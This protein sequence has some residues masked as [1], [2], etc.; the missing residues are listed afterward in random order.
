MVDAAQVQLTLDLPFEEAMGVEDFI[1]ASPNAQAFDFIT[2]WPDW[3]ANVAVLCG[4]SGSGKTHL[5]NIWTTLSGARQHKAKNLRL[6]VI[7]QWLETGALVV[8]DFQAGWFDEA[9]LFHL[10]NAVRGGPSHLLITADEPP[11]KWGLQTADIMSR[12]RAAVP[13]E[14]EI[15]DDALMRHIFVKQFSDRQI[16]VEPNVIDYLLFRI[17]RSLNAVRECV[18]MLDE[19]AFSKGRP[20]TRRFAADV[21]GF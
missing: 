21:L 14:I 13:I 11:V 16:I 19:A 3:P 6:D 7:P 4:P 15:P 12:L 17:E 18:A 8:E 5:A 10:V 20:I 1:V 2:K 9:A